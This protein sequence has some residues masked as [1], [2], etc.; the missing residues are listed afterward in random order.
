[1][2]ISVA[3]RD[4]YKAR[5]NFGL[6]L[7]LDLETG[8]FTAPGN[9]RAGIF[10]NAF[11]EQHKVTELLR[12]ISSFFGNTVTPR[13]CHRLIPEYSL[14]LLKLFYWMIFNSK[15]FG[16]FGKLC[17]HLK[18]IH[19][20]KTKAIWTISRLFWSELNKKEKKTVFTGCV[21]HQIINYSPYNQEK[22][23]SNVGPKIYQ[24]PRPVLGL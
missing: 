22:T 7:I 16:V 3:W 12:N 15:H 21:I 18:Y 8:R 2:N 13:L 19:F 1:M 23:Y 11:A 17:K 5:W 4:N 14:K 6:I 24:S 20:A 9:C 10:W